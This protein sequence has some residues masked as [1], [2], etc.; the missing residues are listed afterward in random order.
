MVELAAADLADERL[1]KRLAATR[2]VRRAA[3][4]RDPESYPAAL[5][6]AL[7]AWHV[8]GT[9]TIAVLNTAERARAVFDALEEMAHAADLLLLHARFRAQE[10]SITAA[11][12]GTRLPSAGRI[13]VATQALEAG[14]DTSC[15]TMFTESAPWSSIVARAGRCNR[16]GDE[17]GAVLVWA[18]PPA[19]RPPA[20]PYDALRVAAAE[21]ALAALEGT[22]VTAAMLAD[23][24]V[25]REHPKHPPLSQADL[26]QL[27]DTAPVGRRS[28]GATEPTAL[29]ST[30]PRGSVTAST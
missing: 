6:G 20:A 25:P 11:L 9:A 19:C 24:R 4:P 17:P 8:P 10:R 22:V 21:E 14:V 16:A 18:P 13:V 26:C 3:L 2:V 30:S 15:Q 1:A 23:H 5:A 28:R 29:A 7:A 12:V 27:F